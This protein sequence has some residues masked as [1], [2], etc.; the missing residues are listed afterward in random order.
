[1]GE[2]LKNLTE[3]IEET[4]EINNS[5]RVVLIGH[6]M[7]NNYVLYLLNQMPS[8]WK[9]KYIEAFISIA[10]PWAGSVKTLR[11]IASGCQMDGFIFFYIYKI[12]NKHFVD[13]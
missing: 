3:L 6:S 5:T 12:S 1:M 13:Y 7:G 11:L 9:K 4:Y 10:A 8:K 2:F